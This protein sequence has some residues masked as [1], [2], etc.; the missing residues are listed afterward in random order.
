MTRFKLIVWLAFPVLFLIGP[1]LP[2]ATAAALASDLLED[3]LIYL[4][5]DE[6]QTTQ[7]SSITG[8]SAITGEVTVAQYGAA[9]L[10][11]SNRGGFLCVRFDFPY[12]QA[13]TVTR[14]SFP[15]RTQN[16]NPSMPA[17]FRSVRVMGM[18][19]TGMPD[20]SQTYF[21][22]RRYLGSSTGGTNDIPLS[23]ALSG[24]TTLF[25]VFDFPTPSA[26]IA[27]T[28][29]F[30]LTDR[31]FT[32]LG[33]FV[34]SY[35]TDTSAAVRTVPSPF[36]GTFAGTAILADQNI[37]ASMTSQLTDVAPL[38]APSGLGLNVRDSVAV[39]T[40]RNPANV[41]AD[42]T[43]APDGYLAAVE[44]VNRG[45][46]WTPVDTG[47]T[48]ERIALTTLPPGMQIWGVAAI[49]QAGNRSVVSNVTIS[50]ATSVV[51]T[52]ASISEDA[53][54][55]NGRASEEEATA[56]T[57]PATDRPETVWPAG[58]E[59]NYWFLATSNDV[60]T[61]RVVPTNLDFRNDLAPVIHI[62][63]KQGD[64][65]A[66]AAAEPGG[67]AEIM[68]TVPLKRNGRPQT[69]RFFVQVRDM[70]GSMVDPATGPRVL[71]PPTYN[72]TVEVNTP[73]AL[74]PVS[75]SDV[76][77]SSL[78]N[79]DAMAFVNAGRNPVRHEATFGF[80]IPRSASGGLP[81][82]IRVY[83]LRGRLMSTLVDGTVTPGT[84]YATWSGHDAR[85]HRAGSGAYFARME[86]GSWRRSVRIDL[87]K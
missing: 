2:N 63:D 8:T 36:I 4:P 61:A 15:S 66:T 79:S 67:T 83:D 9:D 20:K 54:E 71:I 39:F 73:A 41:L 24:P 37:H 86:A 35:A 1:A 12:D 16:Q 5:L 69:S 65:L 25:A 48:N 72:L 51:G 26:G 57:L 21:H 75:P 84:H 76:P 31:Q 53:D 42:G 10:A 32:D 78:L 58:E 56:L 23:I 70:S 60:I 28:F 64:V 27:D 7:S 85:G 50:G 43:A 68:Y 49:D 74:S 81:V 77:V 33:L 17:S 3:G 59:D 40:Y 87:V 52:T 62:L 13:Y 18:T 29:P 80:V 11:V 30:N 38:N 6:V 45:V 19:A 47:G 22:Q 55:P 82:K 46:S 44:L 14:L 34:N